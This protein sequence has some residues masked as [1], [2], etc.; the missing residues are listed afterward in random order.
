MDAP[1]QRNRVAEAV[2]VIGADL[3]LPAMLQRIVAAAAD[4]V[5]AHSGALGV[6]DETGDRL[7]ELVT[8]GLDADARAAISEHP[9][10]PGFFPDHP[11]MTSFLD[12]PIRVRGEVFANLYLRDKDGGEAFSEVD[13]ELAA[14]LAAAAGIAIHSAQ[15]DER[16]RR[17]RQRMAL[18]RHREQISREL[19]D[20]V[21][22]RIHGAGFTLTNAKHMTSGD[23]AERIGS[24][25]D[26]LA[27][28]V[29][30]VQGVVF[31]LDAPGSPEAVGIRARILE[32]AHDASHELGFEP[33]I[34]FSGPMDAT[35]AGRRLSDLLITLREA[36]TDVARHGR[37]SQVDI[38][39]ST[40]DAFTLRVSD[41]GDEMPS[42]GQ[43]PGRHH[44]A[45]MRS[46]AERHGGTLH[47]AHPP[48]G[49]T[50]VRWRLPVIEP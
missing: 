23:A 9:D 11:P 21:I 34:T 43:N 17:Q 48:T 10:G 30:E 16:N 14:G 18:Y 33:H 1:R 47:V 13:E 37:A 45:E 5:H 44:R 3:E 28:T 31:D 40:D 46:R 7:A 2:A 42:D 25:V 32:L 15:L 50:D 12:V 26:E 20:S 6:L 27:R 19:H 29:A 4:L 49:G 38:E 36:L 35:V 8:V 22:R 24:A 39:L 41:D